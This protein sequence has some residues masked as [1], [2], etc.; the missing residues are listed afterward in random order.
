LTS[1]VARIQ[2]HPARASILPRLLH[3]LA[4]LCAEVVQHSSQ[5]ADPWGGYKLC[6]SDIPDCSHLLILQDDCIPVPGFAEALPAIAEANP[7]R[8]VCLW[9]GAIPANA[10]ARARRAYGKQRFIPLGPAPFVPLVAVLWPRQAAVEFREW[11]ET[12]ARIT[13]ADDGNVGRWMRQTR[14]EFMVAVPSIVEHDDHTPS[15]K[16]GTPETNGKDRNRVALLLAD[17]ARDWY[18]SALPV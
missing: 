10:A 14:Q 3:H 8:P 4:P 1:I 15:V 17:D 18:P 5:P 13:R 12:A 9:M 16:G 6:L 11:S 7:D 2:H